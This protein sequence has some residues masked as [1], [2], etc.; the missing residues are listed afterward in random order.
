[1]ATAL[2]A[3][4]KKF[5]D[6]KG[7]EVA[8]SLQPKESAP[9]PDQ[10]VDAPAVVPR[11]TITEPTTDSGTAPDSQTVPDTSSQKIVN[12]SAAEPEKI[13]APEERQRLIKE[14]GLVPLE[15]L[16]EARG[17][18]KSLRS[19]IQRLQEWQRSLTDQLRQTVLAPAHEEIPDINQ[20]PIAY[21]QWAIGKLAEQNQQMQNW[22]QERSLREQRESQIRQASQWATS[23]EQIFTREHPDYPDA[24]NYVV[25]RRRQE[26]K[27]LGVTDEQ[28]LDKAIANDAQMLVAHAASQQKN[29]A[30]LLYEY[31]K[32][33]GYV[34]KRKSEG[35]VKSDPAVAALERI[36]AGQNASGGLR[37]GAAPVGKLGPQELAAMPVKTASQRAA[38]SK[39]WKEAMG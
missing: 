29:P 21:Q 7:T 16:Q 4:E 23:Q 25:N 33:G 34:A 14:M 32:V 20:D 27:S 12:K 31:A 15:A 13:V 24:W 9:A 39:A 11:E 2:T 28:A 38:F 10:K 17:E 35:S 26:L 5:F 37:G 3:D 22:Q 30:E 19:E 8:Q 1:M 18:S 36:A 6:S